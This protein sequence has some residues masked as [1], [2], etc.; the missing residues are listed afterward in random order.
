MNMNYKKLNF[1][2][3]IKHAS[4]YLKLKNCRPAT[5]GES[6]VNNCRMP[7]EINNSTIIVN[8]TNLMIDGYFRTTWESTLTINVDD[9]V[10]GKPDLDPD[11]ATIYNINGNIEFGVLDFRDSATRTHVINLGED[12]EYLTF[13]DTSALDWGDET[14]QIND[15]RSGVVR[16]GIDDNGLTDVQL[17]NVI[18]D[19][20]GE[21]GV[22]LDANG[23]LIPLQSTRTVIIVQ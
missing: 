8:T 23:W 19:G 10:S 20:A 17:A 12:V 11:S 18:A 7:F 2:G 4:D 21:K 6:A 9:A 15:F 5:F 16:F 22:E 13:Q 14:L 3:E 1:F